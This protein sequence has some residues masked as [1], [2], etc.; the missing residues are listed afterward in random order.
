M[1][2]RDEVWTSSELLI[3]SVG[4]TTRLVGELK[5]DNLP[6]PISCALEI[7]FEV[8]QRPMKMSDVKPYLDGQ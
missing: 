3:A 7:E 5:G 4:G 6:E 2:P 1:R 8:K